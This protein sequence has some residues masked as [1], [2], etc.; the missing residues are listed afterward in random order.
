MELELPVLPALSARDHSRRFDLDGPRSTVP[1]GQHEG[2]IGQMTTATTASS[3][4][5]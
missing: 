4:A 2:G 1:A 3:A 5:R